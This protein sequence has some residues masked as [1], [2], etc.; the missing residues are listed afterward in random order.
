[1]HRIDTSTAQKDKFGAGKNGFTGGNPQTGELPTA[2]DQFFFDSLQEEICG[3][4]E[5]GG[6][7][8]N[9]ADR[10]QMLKAMKAMFPLL[11]QFG[12]SQASPGYQKLPGGLV[13]QW[14]T[15]AIPTSG[16]ATVSFPLLF[17]KGI[18][19]LIT[20]LDSSSSNNYRVAVSTSTLSTMTMTSTNT[21]N[22]TGV[23]WMAAGY[24]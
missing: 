23:M 24:I 6:I 8:L 22:T 11:S 9:K 17:T 5:G 2:L 13:I 7:A 15:G 3:V 16:S 10:G 19:Q 18:F 4:I 21:Q 12:N 14:G 20:P 1:M